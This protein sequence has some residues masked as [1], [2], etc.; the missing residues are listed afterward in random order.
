[1]K[2]ANFSI[3]KFDIKGTH[4]SINRM[5]HLTTSLAT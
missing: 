5:I 3:Y 2:G 1:M 4:T